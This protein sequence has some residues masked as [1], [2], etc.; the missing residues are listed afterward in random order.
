MIEQVKLE[1]SSAFSMVDIGPVSF[2]LDLKLQR[3]RENWKIKLSQPVY[4]DKILSKFQFDKAYTVNTP[5]K[6]SAILK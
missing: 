1:L 6:K 2:Y 5:M 4:I 3:D